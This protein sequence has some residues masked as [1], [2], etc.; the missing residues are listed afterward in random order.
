NGSLS[1]PA[2]LQREKLSNT[3]GARYNPCGAMQVKFYLPP[4]GERT[5]NI[6][7]GSASS[8]E[9]VSEYMKR[10][11]RG[12]GVETAYQGVKQ[13]WSDLLGRVQVQTPDRAFDLLLNHWLLYQTVSCRLWARSAFYQ[14]GGAYGFRDQL[15]DSLAL[16]HAR[17][18]VARKQILR[19]AAH[20]YREGDVQHWWHEE[21]GYGIRTRFSDDLL[22]L[23]YAACRYANHTGDQRIWNHTIPF[24]ESP[25]LAEGE[26]ER[27][28]ETKISSETG[29]IYE[30]CVRAI[31]RSLHFGQHGL[32]LMGT[33]DWNDGMSQ[34]GAA[35]IG[36]S[37]WLGWFLYHVLQEFVPF[38]EVQGD[39]DRAAR[40]R[41]IGEK[42]SAALN[43]QAWDG[44][45]YRRAYNDQGEPLGSITNLECQ[46]DCIAQAWGVISGAADPDKAFM[47]MRSLDDKLV[48]RENGSLICLLTPP[49]NET[50]PSPGYIQAYPPGIR[51]NGGQYTHGTIWAV[52]AW[53]MLGEGNKAY[54][55]FHI[56][57][58]INHTRT[59]NEVQRY[60]VE[61]YVMAADVYSVPPY[62]G[63][64]GWSWYTGSAGWMYQ[65][66]LEW[67]LGIQRQGTTLY[68]KPTIP[69]EWPEYTVNYRYGQTNYEIK[70][71]NPNRKQSGG[72]YL[73]LDGEELEKVADGVP[74]VNDGRRHRIRFVL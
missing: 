63:R 14:A 2:A 25:P 20:Q 32:P 7:I 73:E 47:S 65:A 69:E 56:L 64:G 51:E 5:V 1:F 70:V 26:Q 33:G 23:P 34:V 8:K 61:P 74:L 18:G 60:K 43:E 54:E 37:V 42:L 24:L 46:I 30:H 67:I 3:T 39:P 41:A 31:E 62:V 27:Y 9:Q 28:E 49:F 59:D 29:T 12:T 38:A 52:I 35:G 53:A 55:L 4:R 57:N 16:L 17:P 22:W 13:Y 50:E 72:S 66:G 40:Y 68:L 45:W 10:Y 15:Q 19:H 44:Q 6:L 36:E 48:L 58:P 21:T 71:E 11:G